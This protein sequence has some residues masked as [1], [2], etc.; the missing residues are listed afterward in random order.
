MADCRRNFDASRGARGFL[1][2][3]ALPVAIFFLFAV[4]PLFAAF[5]A[6]A[7]VLGLVT[8]VMIFAIAALALDL[9]IGY[10]AL[11]SFG[12]A[13]FVGLGAYAVGILTSHGINDA[14]ISLPVALGVSALFALATGIVCLRTKGVYFI[15]ITLAF[16]QMAYFT[17]S[18]L[19]P[20]GGDDGLTI[21][22][23]STLAGFPIFNGDRSLYYICL[24]LP[25]RRVSLVPRACRLA[26]RPRLSRR[27]RE[28]AARRHHRL[29]GLSL[30]AR[31]LRDRRRDRRALRAS[32]SPTRPTSS[33]RPTCRG[34]ARANCS[35]W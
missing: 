4:L 2:G 1:S 3:N 29:R 15:M 5:S 27:A 14:L 17:A 7:Y 20:Y 23:R 9:L 6:E 18:S 31:R 10:G 25:A 22:M 11:V 19:A 28:S 34:S 32:C 30:S 16:G 12:H 21:R 33:A 13:A 35:S 26:L 24:R 8:R